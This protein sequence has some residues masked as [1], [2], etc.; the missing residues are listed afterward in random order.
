ESFPNV[1]IFFSDIVGFT[2]ICGRCSPQ[3]VLNFLNDLYTR[4]DVVLNSYNV[5][6][7]IIVTMDVLVF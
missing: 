2:S 3:E 4:F 7:V 6:K 5:Y 1:T